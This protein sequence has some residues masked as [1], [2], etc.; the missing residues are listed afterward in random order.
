MLFFQ[1][2]NFLTCLL[3]FKM[4]AFRSA[5]LNAKSKD[6]G[7]TLHFLC[8]LKKYAHFFDDSMR[9]FRI[10]TDYAFR[11]GRLSHQIYSSLLTGKLSARRVFLFFICHG[12]AFFLFPFSL[13]FSF[14]NKGFR[15]CRRS[16]AFVRASGCPRGKRH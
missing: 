6:Q 8:Q 10:G 3:P 5:P 13:C 14:Q 12:H 7:F 16:R 11:K 9:I 2:E 1:K 15:I 4:G